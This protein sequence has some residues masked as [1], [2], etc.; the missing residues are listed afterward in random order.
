MKCRALLSVSLLVGCAG[1]N[2]EPAAYGGADSGGPGLGGS[3]T[4]DGSTTT[5]GS[6]ATAGAGGSSGAAGGAAPVIAAGVRWVGRVDVSSPTAIKFAWSGSGFV[7]TFTGAVVSAKLKTEGG[8]KIFFQ[9]LVDGTQGARFSV[10]ASEQVVDI[11]SNLGPGQHRVE[12]YRETEGKGF[13]YSVFSGFTRG[14]ASA[15]PAASGRLIE[16][17]G[18]S[19]SAGFGNLGAEQHPNYMQDPNGGCPFTSDTE[20][21]YQAYGPAAARAV[22][23]E[24]SVLAGSGWGMYSDNQGNQANVMPSLFASTVGEQKMPAW[25]F[26]V[27]PQAV[28]INLG[29]NDSSAH[30]LT[31]DKFKPAYAAFLTVVR[32]KYPDALILCAVGSMLG[33]TDRDNA[34]QYLTDIIK[35]RA[36]K[37]DTKVKLLDLGTQDVLKG[38]GCTW[39]PNIAEDQR[40]AALLS[41]ELKSS[42]GW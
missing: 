10:G 2:G 12:L 22:N 24:A 41:A 27:Q 6:S 34:V 4:T 26:A 31:A 35:E 19:I 23:A 38:T 36:G 30:N 5:A 37:G 14:A 18:D 33:G 9:P 20:S 28:V 42:L 21:A 13:G 40:M 1:H 7:G 3:A 29:T 8:G 16:V 39:H 15:P 17:I 11:A 32:G 25:S